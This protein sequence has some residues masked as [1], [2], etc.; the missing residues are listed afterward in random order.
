MGGTSLV[1]TVEP[2]AKPGDETVTNVSARPI[3][4]DLIE[5]SDLTRD[6][7]HLEQVAL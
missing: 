1:L 2:L 6:R 5:F 3:L 7:V 4:Y